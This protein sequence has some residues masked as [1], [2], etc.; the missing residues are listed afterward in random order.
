MSDTA[1]GTSPKPAVLVVDDAID[2]LTLLQDLLQPH[3][4]VMAAVN[5]E[6]GL[7]IAASDHPPD[8]ILLDI[9]MPGIDGYEVCRRLKADAATLDIPV[10]F[11]TA[12][13]EDEDE[14][15]G[16][17]LGA[18]DY[19]TKPV[20]PPVL[21]ARVA[22]HLALKAASDA[23]RGRNTQLEVEVDKRTRE[24]VAIQDATILVLTTLAEARDADT[25]NHIRRTQG[26]VRALARKLSTHPDYADFLTSANILLLYKSAPLHD[27]GKVGIPDRILL[28]PGK[29][30]P[31]EFEIMKTHTQVGRDAITRGEEALGAHV[32]FLV[33]AREIAYTHHE[34]WDGT[35]YPQGLKGTDIPI[36][37]RLMAVADVYDALICRRVYKEPMAHEQA[38]KI[39]IGSSGQHFDPTVVDAFVSIED[40]IRAIAIAYADTESDLAQKR[41]YFATAGFTEPGALG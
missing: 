5:G 16:F 34:K 40:T 23:M 17:A 7:A 12:K 24:L 1:P 29:L 37:G 32:P 26:Y 3:Y 22:T 20:S 30:T 8:L 2:S 31:E 6:R 10:I 41:E 11:L 27:V 21:L 19:I 33:L 28:K 39:I 35:G 25:G 36:S 4:R 18:V 14:T 9:M 38:M 15:Q 13:T